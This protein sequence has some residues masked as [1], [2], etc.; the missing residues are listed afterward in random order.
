MQKT[1]IAFALSAA[2]ALTACSKS[3]DPEKSA[4]NTPAPV[5]EQSAPAVQENTSMTDKA[6][7]AGKETWEKTK[8]VA[9]DTADT[10]ATKSQEIYEGTKEAASDAG[11]AIADKA[12]EIGTAISEK[13][14]DVYDAAKETTTDMVDATKEKGAEM[15]DSMKKE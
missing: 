2:L 3:E 5:T 13:S 6:M 12:D 7:Q 14:S 9:S 15:L 11:D 1:T 8:E 10:V 4:S